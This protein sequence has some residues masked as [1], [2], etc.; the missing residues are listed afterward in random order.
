[1]HTSE[2]YKESEV[3]DVS[4][5]VPNRYITGSIGPNG[6][7]T[8]TIIRMILDAVRPDEGDIRILNEP[9]HKSPLREKIGFVYDPLHIYEDFNLKKAKAFI[10]EVYPSWDDELYQ[11]YVDRFE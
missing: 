7:G 11:K 3:E 8:S 10:S 5:T 2:N 6:S 1:N 9:N 4:F